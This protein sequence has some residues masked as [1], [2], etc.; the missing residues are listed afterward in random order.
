MKKNLALQLDWATNLLFVVDDCRYRQEANDTE[1]VRIVRAGFNVNS[2]E[3]PFFIDLNP[4]KSA[5]DRELFKQIQMGYAIEI[6]R[7]QM[8]S[9]SN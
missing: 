8:A 5:L 4:M 7:F 9:I 6:L 2:V 1:P 3:N